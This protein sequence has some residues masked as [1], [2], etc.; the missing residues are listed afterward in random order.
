MYTLLSLWG[1]WRARVMPVVD[2]V[3]AFLSGAL[4]LLWTME[5]VSGHIQ[6]IVLIAWAVVFAVASFIV[7][8]WGAPI[9][10]FYVYAGVASVLLSVVLALELDGPA[11]TIASLCEAV[12]VLVVGYTVSRKHSHVPVLALPL[13]VPL[14]LSFEHVVRFSNATTLWNQH[15]VTLLVHRYTIWRE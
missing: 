9:T 1:V 3:T 11:L 6:S 5:V 7:V 12:V 15:M 13:I 4:L 14:L 10:V 2:A 8:R